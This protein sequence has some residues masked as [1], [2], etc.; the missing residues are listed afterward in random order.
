MGSLNAH[1]CQ[2]AGAR[3]HAPS[4]G[5]DL[6]RVFREL[7]GVE[8]AACERELLCLL[9]ERVDDLGMAMALS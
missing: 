3:W 4:D 8:G 9:D 6:L 5:S 2:Q 1:Y 7:V